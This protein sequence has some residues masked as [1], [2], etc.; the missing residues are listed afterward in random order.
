[1]ASN[2]RWG[3]TFW[4]DLKNTLLTVILLVLYIGKS[5]HRRTAPSYERAP[6]D[7]KP[8]FSGPLSL[9]SSSNSVL[10][11]DKTIGFNAPET[12]P[13]RMNMFFHFFNSCYLNI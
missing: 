2:N 11:Q 1:L 9:K 10:V 8:I 12:P 5:G 13:V 3:Y 6:S 4:Y 7:H